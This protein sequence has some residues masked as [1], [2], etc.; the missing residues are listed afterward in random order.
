MGHL[1]LLLAVMLSSAPAAPLEVANVKL[2]KGRDGQ[3]LELATL[4]PTADKQALV[5]IN[6]ANCEVDGLVLRGVLDA[7][8]DFVTR[9]HGADWTLA[10]FTEGR[11][12]VSAPG[13]EFAVT[14]S[15]AEPGALGAELATAH[16]QQTSSGALRLLARKP[17]PFLEKKYTDKAQ[18]A[19]TALNAACGSS[20]VF[21]F[22]WG[23]FS[24]QDMAELDVWA[25]CEPL[26]TAAKSRCAVVKGVTTLTCSRGERFDVLRTPGG[27]KFITTEQ[28][29][30]DGRAWLT[31]NLGKK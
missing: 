2:Y 4:Q 22:D 9:I 21:A 3:T 30:A 18:A 14:F 13:A 23:S 11:A 24:D 29:K 26:V 27:L 20:A 8:G 7:R 12:T 6:A 16:A 17:F 25:L 5:R 15:A 19:L 1:G 10:R 31:T 28:G